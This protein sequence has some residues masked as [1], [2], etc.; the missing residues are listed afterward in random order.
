MRSL[1]LVILAIMF[2]GTA[3]SESRC[4]ISGDAQLWAYDACFWRFET[5]DSIHPGVLK[6]ANKNIAL[7]SK[8]GSCQAKRIFKD[9]IC[10]IARKQKLSDPDP[11][12]CMTSDKPLGAAVKDGGI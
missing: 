3:Q 1:L 7:I 4:E 11:N 8:V 5:D 6:C 2:S 12:T 9:R 10:A